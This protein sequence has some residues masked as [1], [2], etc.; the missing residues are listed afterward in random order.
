MRASFI[1][2][3][4][5]AQVSFMNRSKDM[6]RPFVG[7]VADVLARTRRAIGKNLGNA[8]VAL[9]R[10]HCC[11]RTRSNVCGDGHLEL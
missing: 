3:R 8:L 10:S 4:H 2:L 6:V 5:L 11:F 9:R 1:G 7:S